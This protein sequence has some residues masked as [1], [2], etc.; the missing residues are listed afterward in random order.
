MGNQ[1]SRETP[2]GREDSPARTR[3]VLLAQIIAEA[4][5]QPVD[6]VQ[7]LLAN[8]QAVKPGSIQDAAMS[9][10]EYQ[11]MLAQFRKELP[12]IRAWLARGAADADPAEMAEF[13]FRALSRN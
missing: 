1:P 3:T 11:G 4:S 10:D 5:G 9:E 2:A 7:G 6:Q 13:M 12:G 8:F